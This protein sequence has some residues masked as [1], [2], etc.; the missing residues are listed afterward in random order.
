MTRLAQGALLYSLLA[1]SYMIPGYAK[2]INSGTVRG[3][4]TDPTGA[5]VAGA[6][7]LMRNPVTGYEQTVRT[8]SDGKF[9]FNNIPQNNYR[10]SATAPGFT[11]ATQEVD[12]R[13]S[14][15]ITTN[16]SLKLAV[17]STTVDV[18][19]SAFAVEND[20]SAHQDV[21]RSSFLKLPTFDPRGPL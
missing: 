11:A 2:S 16:F 20:P 1:L 4:V 6:Q 7:V 13:S 5:V 17:S 9:R 21:D 12:V 10:L 19:A 3:T 18:Q 8:D 14:V 15:P